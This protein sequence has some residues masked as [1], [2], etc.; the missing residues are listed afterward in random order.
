MSSLTGL[1]N[2][3]YLQGYL[4]LLNTIQTQDPEGW[5]TLAAHTHELLQNLQTPYEIWSPSVAYAVEWTM[6]LVSKQ[7]SERNILMHR[8]QPQ[9][10][11]QEL[12]M[13]GCTPLSSHLWLSIIDSTLKSMRLYT[14]LCLHTEAADHM[15]WIGLTTGER[16][17]PPCI[18][19]DLLEGHW[20]EGNPSYWQQAPALSPLGSKYWQQNTTPGLAPRGK[21]LPQRSRSTMNYNKAPLDL[22]KEILESL[23]TSFYREV[24]EQPPGYLSMFTGKCAPEPFMEAAG[25]QLDAACE[26]EDFLQAYIRHKYPEAAIANDAILL[27]AQ[28]M[29]WN[30]PS[31]RLPHIEGMIAGPPCQPFSKAGKQ[32]GAADQRAIR[33]LDVLHV[34]AAYKVAW[35]IIENVVDL[36]DGDDKHGLYTAIIEVAAS[37]NYTLTNKEKVRDGD[38]GGV[39]SRTRL[40]LY[41][42]QADIAIIMPP[43]SMFTPQTSQRQRKLLEVLDSPDNI[44]SRYWIKGHY[45]P[46]RQPPT[47]NVNDN[48]TRV[49]TLIF[50]GS[51]HNPVIIPG[52]EIELWPHPSIPSRVSRWRILLTHYHEDHFLL[53]DA[54]TNT[55]VRCYAWPSLYQVSCRKP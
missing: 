3:K 41:F 23:P 34:A 32:Q 49:G 25:Y 12:A 43:M 24:S 21:S 31:H 48:P 28:P 15:G 19:A 9:M 7:L 50:G 54:I 46:T 30:I 18:Y 40:F 13:A 26:I 27:A 22:G 17:G 33:V 16:L 36:L 47:V 14:W 53:E 6:N 51:E 55:N 29:S 35:I 5:S 42:E 11:L 10:Q 8:L 1:A 39:M 45:M 37:H 38:V 2:V 52:M 20:Q 44:H 4:L